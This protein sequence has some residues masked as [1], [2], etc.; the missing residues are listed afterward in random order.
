MIYKKRVIYVVL[1]LMQALISSNS[2]YASSIDKRA[3]LYI[4]GTFEDVSGE[5]IEGYINLDGSRVWIESFTA[6]KQSNPY[7]KFFKQ[8]SDVLY[9]VGISSSDI[10]VH[11][12]SCRYNNIESI[13]PLSQNNISLTLKGGRSASLKYEFSKKI[14]I[15]PLSGGVREVAWS[16]MVELNFHPAPDAAKVPEAYGNIVVARVE[17]VQGQYYGIL[18][19]GQEIKNICKRADADIELTNSSGGRTLLSYMGGSVSLSST[20]QITVYMPSIGSVELPLSKIK[21]IQSGNASMLQNAS[22]NSSE[23]VARIA[24]K[25]E[26]KGEKPQGGYI[27][28]D[29]D[30]ALNIEFLEGYNDGIKYTILFGAIAGIEPRNYNFSL[31]KL[32]GGGVVSL[33]DSRDVNHEND[34]ILMLATGYYTPWSSVKNITMEY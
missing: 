11:S 17:S 14:L 23:P 21:K 2:S 22:Y 13:R 3:S 20:T 34:G 28:Y 31:V 7:A 5:K 4:Y 25:V 32:L 24:A 30:E 16:N 33:G 6:T 15:Y 1:L 12:F 26:V 10:S 8:N 27:A 18:A 9:A 29:L 19:C